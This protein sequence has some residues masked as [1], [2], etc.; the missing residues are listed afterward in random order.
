MVLKSADG[1][2]SVPVNICNSY[3]H[4]HET[5]GLSTILGKPVF[6]KVLMRTVPPYLTS[7]QPQLDHMKVEA[8]RP[9]CEVNGHNR[10]LSSVR[11][12]P[13]MLSVIEICSSGAIPTGV[14]NNYGSTSH[15]GPRRRGLGSGLVTYAEARDDCPQGITGRFHRTQ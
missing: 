9:S 12:A 14:T 10:E 7:Q 4:V 13:N 1:R 8:P 15:E 11:F 6:I 3:V 5:L 2:K